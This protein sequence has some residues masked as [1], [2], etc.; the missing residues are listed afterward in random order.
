MYFCKEFQEVVAVPR[1]RRYI[2]GMDVQV[3]LVHFLRLVRI[4]HLVILVVCKQITF[5][6]LYILY[7]HVYKDAAVSICIYIYF[8]NRTG[9]NQQLFHLF[10]ANRVCFPWSANDKRC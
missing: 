3:Y 4:V 10:A 5:V 8:K 7:I 6:C 2:V 9:G 1:G